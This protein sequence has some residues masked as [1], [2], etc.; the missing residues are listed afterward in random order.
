MIETGLAQT[1]RPASPDPK[2]AAAATGATELK[3]DMYLR[4]VSP[5]CPRI[6]AVRDELS[7]FEGMVPQRDQPLF[8]F[9]EIFL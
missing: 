9:W 1:R 8:Y 6:F 3:G 5:I 7:D 2:S 4:Y